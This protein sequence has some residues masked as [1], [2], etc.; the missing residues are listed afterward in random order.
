MSIS[1]SHN[2]ASFT[3][4]H[5]MLQ[6]SGSKECSSEM[7]LETQQPKPTMMD[8]SPDDPALSPE[9]SFTFGTKHGPQPCLT[10]CVI[11]GPFQIRT[12]NSIGQEILNSDGH[13]IAWT[14]DPWVT[15]N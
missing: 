8:S 4:C 2:L 11:H 12:N 10:P 14:T 1:A 13:T 6:G 3:V 7:I 9:L 5:P 15:T